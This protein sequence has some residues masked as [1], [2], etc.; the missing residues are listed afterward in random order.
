M[1]IQA[2]ITL[3]MLGLP[4]I[5]GQNVGV[6]ATMN[7]AE[8]NVSCEAGSVQQVQE[9]SSEY[10]TCEDGRWNAA[11]CAVGTFD[12]DTKTCSP[13]TLNC[14]GKARRKRALRLR[15]Q[16]QAVQNGDCSVSVSCPPDLIRPFVYPYWDSCDSYILCESGRL[17]IV[18]C[19]FQNFNYYNPR[20]LSCEQFA[21]KTNTC[22]NRFNTNLSPIRN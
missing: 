20:T 9:C 10:K 21:S 1:N 4:S 22:V 18:S 16:T 14:P 7:Q 17:S 13:S 3:L 12:M 8:V 15:R 6:E 11:I 2:V 19:A 5:A